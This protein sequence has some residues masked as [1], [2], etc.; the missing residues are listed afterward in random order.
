MQIIDPMQ[1]LFPGARTSIIWDKHNK[2]TRAVN[3]RVNKKTKI[4]L[5]EPGIAVS[6]YFGTIILVIPNL[7]NYK[8]SLFSFTR[9]TLKYNYD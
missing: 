8:R 4:C 7:E 9:T 1:P 5:T 2:V 3:V 6:V